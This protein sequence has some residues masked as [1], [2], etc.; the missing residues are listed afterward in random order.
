MSR[1]GERERDAERDGGCVLGAALRLGIFP[2]LADYQPLHI[3]RFA[4]TD[5]QR[6]KRRR[7]NPPSLAMPPERS[8]HPS[9]LASQA[10]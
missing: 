10:A 6:L 9:R 5:V 1:G 3:T 4:Q 7:G 2:A 8:P